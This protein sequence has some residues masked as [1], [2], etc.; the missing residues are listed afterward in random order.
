MDIRCPYCGSGNAGAIHISEPEAASGDPGWLCGDCGKEFGKTPEF[1]FD[2]QKKTVS[3]LTGFSFRI[4][5]IWRGHKE[6]IIRRGEEGAALCVLFSRSP[7]DEG[8]Y[9]RRFQDKEWDDLTKILFT[10]LFIHEWEQRYSS[11]IRDGTQ[12]GLQLTFTGGLQYEIY[13]NNKYPPL[14]GSFK[15]EMDFYFSSAMIIK[16]DPADRQRYCGL[17][18]DVY[19]VQ[20][21]IDAHQDETENAGAKDPGRKQQ[22][23]SAAPDE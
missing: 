11:N 5:G 7:S 15:K 13:G 18:R 22:T 9:I 19:A 20:G 10:D 14:W 3:D 12:W 8:P 23:G 16:P 2:G 21:W 4:G 6:I 1:T 17:F